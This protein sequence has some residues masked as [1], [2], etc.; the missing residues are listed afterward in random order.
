MNVL[1]VEDLG[2]VR[3]I[4]DYL[5]EIER[6]HLG[7]E[8]SSFSL[9]TENA[10]ANM[11]KADALI[12]DISQLAGQ[13]L[14]EIALL[15]QNIPVIGTL[16]PAPGMIIIESD[17]FKVIVKPE[18]DLA[19]FE[20]AVMDIHDLYRSTKRLHAAASMVKALYQKLDQNRC[21][22]ALN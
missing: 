2:V 4:A 7:M 11:S 19:R 14:A 8:L 9:D 5:K 10:R 15:E 12:V 17:I 3:V 16:F 22:C 18:F 6:K 20:Q 1:I 21:R 13:E